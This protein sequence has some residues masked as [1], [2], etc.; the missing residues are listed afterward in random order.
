MKL[1]QDAIIVGQN[2]H[3]FNNHLRI[4]TATHKPTGVLAPSLPKRQRAAIPNSGDSLASLSK[5]GTFEM[6]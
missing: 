3:N 4:I 6:D 5:N 2:A 1:L